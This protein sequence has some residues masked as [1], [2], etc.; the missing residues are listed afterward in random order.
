[1][2][3]ENAHR[4]TISELCPVTDQHIGLQ[5]GLNTR[6][7]P[8]V[9]KIRDISRFI[10]ILFSVLVARQIDSSTSTSYFFHCLLP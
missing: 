8:S 4:S 1:M 10:S 9:K 3:V 7:I 6:K 2:H 5:V